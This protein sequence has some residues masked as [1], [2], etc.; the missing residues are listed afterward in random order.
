MTDEN[1]TQNDEL[2]QLKSQVESFKLILWAL[3]EASGG[4]I[5]INGDIYK[6]APKELAVTRYDDEVNNC[7][8]FRSRGNA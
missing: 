5:V 1:Q 7:V 4:E 3:I 6:N 8:V 2:E